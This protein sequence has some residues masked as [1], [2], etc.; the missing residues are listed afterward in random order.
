MG[1]RDIPTSEN[2]YMFNIW[3]AYQILNSRHFTRLNDQL[4]H[5][6]LEELKVSSL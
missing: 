1:H 4:A 5:N 3:E 2:L 6:F